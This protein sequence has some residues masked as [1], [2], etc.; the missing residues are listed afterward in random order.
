[1][2]DAVE[3]LKQRSDGLT[4]TFQQTKNDAATLLKHLFGMD[5]TAVNDDDEPIEL[6]MVPLE[7]TMELQ[8]ML[9]HA[10]AV[11]QAPPVL[12]PQ[13][14][15]DAVYAATLQQLAELR[16]RVD[17][18]TA[19]K[20][21][22]EQRHGLV[23]EYWAKLDAPMAAVA[24]PDDHARLVS[25]LQ[26]LLPVYRNEVKI[27]RA[28]VRQYEAAATAFL[29]S[30]Y[31]SYPSDHA[32]AVEE[33]ELRHDF[34]ESSRRLL[35]DFPDAL[36]PL[37]A[38]EICDPVQLQHRIFE[39]E[40]MIAHA[41]IAQVFYSTKAKHKTIDRAPGPCTGEALQKDLTT[42]LAAYDE[43]AAALDA[44]VADDAQ[45]QLDQQARAPPTTPLFAQHSALYEKLRRAT[46]KV[47]SE[48]R[49]SK[50]LHHVLALAR[51]HAAVAPIASDEIHAAVAA[52]VVD[53][54]TAL[55][56]THEAHM[57]SVID[58]HHLE[59]DALAGAEPAD[60]AA[61]EAEHKAE[62]FAI[63]SLTKVC[64]RRKA[65]ALRARAN[66]A[67]ARLEHMQAHHA[68]MQMKL[69]TELE[70]R[71]SLEH[72]RLLARLEKRRIA[73]LA[74]ASSKP[75]E[76]ASPISSEDDV[77][78]VKAEIVEER[79][80]EWRAAEVVCA[81]TLQ[82]ATVDA[83]AAEAVTFGLGD[84][85]DVVQDLISQLSQV[86]WTHTNCT[87]KQIHAV[88]KVLLRM[89]EKVSAP[90]RLNTKLMSPHIVAHGARPSPAKKPVFH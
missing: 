15:T 11:V 23:R 21:Y 79:Q 26:L 48:C 74:A 49:L 44:C 59:L 60:V 35:Q 52:A 50:T 42:A 9:L 47:R 25:S 2:G 84:D 71:E 13:A 29:Q 75:P 83:I 12:V 86:D 14:L 16:F 66:A 18:M 80:A 62:L 57:Q 45:F 90:K 69:Q 61:A 6:V 39:L 8:K 85:G 73:R 31:L 54:S 40:Y 68:E 5:K 88:E 41:G 87:I 53:A 37:E 1:M 28:G 76:A 3:T 56:T 63:V 10:A 81:T 38:L 33:N 89:R 19:C 30:K 70:T 77:A 64:A 58:A 51:A 27:L 7:P 65:L 82:A 22:I 17:V 36:L 32:R 46:R 72:L 43:A 78:L 67:F 55:T 20:V 34:A 4:R 24:T